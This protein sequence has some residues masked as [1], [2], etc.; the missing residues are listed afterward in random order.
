MLH[1]FA[2][3]VQNNLTPVR[4]AAMF[5]EVD[6]LPGAEGQTAGD[7]GDGEL[8]LRQGGPDVGRHVVRALAAVAVAVG[9]LGH[10]ALEE[11]LQIGADAGIGVF[12]D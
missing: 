8:G 10:E 1:S 11:G 5:E 2:N 3:E 9:G 4:H 6:A 12:L 7:H